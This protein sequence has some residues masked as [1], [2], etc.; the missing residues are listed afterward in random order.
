MQE[1]ILSFLL[2]ENGAASIEYALMASLIALAIIFAVATLGLAT[3]NL[4]D[5]AAD[6]FQ[7]L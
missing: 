6:E 4:F 2:K 7:N 5:S 1:K 3:F